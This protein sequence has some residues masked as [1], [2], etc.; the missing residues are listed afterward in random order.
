MGGNTTKLDNTM[1]RPNEN[2]SAGDISGE[3]VEQ[4][5]GAHRT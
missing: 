4:K 5:Q 3:I 2:F 1:S